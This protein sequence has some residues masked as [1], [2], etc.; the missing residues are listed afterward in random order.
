M[1]HLNRLTKTAVMS[2][3]V[4]KSEKPIIRV[5]KSIGTLEGTLRTF[6]KEHE[7]P[8]TSGAHSVRS[9]AK[10]LKKI[11]QE[12]QQLNPFQCIIG[13]K[14]KSFV[15]L[16]TNMIRSLEEQKFNDC[17]VKRFAEMI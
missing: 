11:L 13:R 14:H 15:N 16:R 5:G 17:M 7:V 4:N 10:D 12:L 3:G 6:D 2:L 8:A 1:E 9:I